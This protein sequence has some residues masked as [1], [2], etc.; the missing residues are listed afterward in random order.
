MRV[1]WVGR[2]GGAEGL[3]RILR[4]AAGAVVGGYM[5]E[6]LGGVDGFW[7][8]VGLGWFIGV[9][10]GL[11]AWIGVVHGLGSRLVVVVETELG[12]GP[13]DACALG[14][15]AGVGTAGEVLRL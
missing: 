10:D 15:V 14:V 11:R 5:G 9:V 2:G 8:P 6:L 3:G 4:G 1:L 7:S 13:G 12:N